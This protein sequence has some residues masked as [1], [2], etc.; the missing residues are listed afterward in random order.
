MPA[1]E[2]VPEEERAFQARLMEVYAG[3]LEHTDTQIGKLIDA[4]EDRGIRD[5]T[6]VIYIFSD[7][8]LRRVH[9]RQFAELNAQNG[10]STTVAEHMAVAEQLAVWKRSVSQDGQHVPLRLAWP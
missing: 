5:N 7:N 1:W 8:A 4:L 2:D 3:F 10:I 6:M 9:E